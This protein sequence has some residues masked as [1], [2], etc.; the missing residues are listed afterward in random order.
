[1]DFV[2]AFRSAEEFVFLVGSWLIL[3]PKTLGRVLVSGGWTFRYVNEQ[4]AK[5]NAE[6]RYVAYVSP[7]LF[8]VAIAVTPYIAVFN[9]YF[10]LSKAPA[11]QA[12]AALPLE[13][14]LLILSI[15]LIGLPIGLSFLYNL[16]RGKI[17]RDS[18]QPM[19][20]T[21]CYCASV[22]QLSLLPYLVNSLA[23]AFEEPIGFSASH[24]GTI[25]ILGLAWFLQM[26]FRVLKTAEGKGN[27][28]TAALTLTYVLLSLVLT[29]VIVVG[30]AKI[31]IE[32]YG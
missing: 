1:M 31:L 7:V 11:D 13:T 12:F 17:D 8:W 19:F 3:V 4:L 5:A 21:Q 26:E 28:V 27:L 2:K 22:F 30:M 24:R 29:G 15:C 14:K 23:K 9:H 6:E 10:S 32:A 16:F 25:A 18:L 20:L